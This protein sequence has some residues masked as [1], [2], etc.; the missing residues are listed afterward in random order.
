M[1]S[2]AALATLAKLVISDISATL[3]TEAS[4][5][6]LAT[7]AILVILAPDINTLVLVIYTLQTTTLANLVPQVRSSSVR[8]LTF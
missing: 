2:F 3:T 5:A 7:L 6:N 1:A 8:R 4:L